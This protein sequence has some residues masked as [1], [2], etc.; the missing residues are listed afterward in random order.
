MQPLFRQIGRFFRGPAAHT[1]GNNSV[2]LNSLFGL[3]ASPSNRNLV[4]AHTELPRLSPV[5]GHTWEHD[6][7]H[8]HPTDRLYG[9]SA[10]EAYVEIGLAHTS[11]SDSTS[12]G[13][14]R[15]RSGIEDGM[16]TEGSEGG[17]LR[18]TDIQ[19]SYSTSPRD[20]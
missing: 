10:M 8:R 13:K 17:I 1:S 14:E 16:S 11:L 7:G 2:P 6:F 15:P 9:A 3:R 12:V 20:A 18:T 19:I 4:T 5:L